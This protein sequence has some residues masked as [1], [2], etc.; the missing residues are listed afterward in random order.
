L[1]FLAAPPRRIAQFTW[2]HDS[3]HIGHYLWNELSGLESISD[4]LRPEKY[5]LIYD[6]GGA[7]GA[8]FYGPISLLF[9]EFKGLTID[10]FTTIPDMLS[11]AYSEGVQV[12]RFSGAFVLAETR[13]RIAN[14]VVGT[15]TV[16]V[17]R[18]ALWNTT[19]PVVVLGL[20]VENRTLTNL[21]EFYVQLCKSLARRFGAVTIIIDGHNRRN[22]SDQSGV[23]SSFLEHR[24]TRPVFEVE[25]EIA[26]AI[27]VGLT[28]Q[29][30][31]VIDCVGMP[32]LENIAWLSLAHY[33]VAPWGAGLAKYRWV[34]NL[35]TYV[36]ISQFCLKNKNDLYIYN[37]PIFMEDP[38]PV[39]FSKPDF[40]VDRPD[41]P[42][43][44]QMDPIH[45]PYYINYEAKIEPISDEIG[46]SIS[47]LNKDAQDWPRHRPH[48]DFRIEN[49]VVMGKNGE[50][51]LA[52]GGHHVLDQV[53]G[54]RK[55]LRISVANFASN[56]ENRAATAAA[57]DAQY[58]HVIFPDKQSVLPADFGLENL[59]CL[60]QYYAEKCKDVWPHVVYPLDALREEP[61]GLFLRT[62]TH[63]THLG[64]LTVVRMVLE[65]LFGKACEQLIGTLHARIGEE[66]PYLGDLGRKLE[67]KPE[68]RQSFI[69]VDPKSKRYSNNYNNGNNGAV[70]VY[71]LPNA[72]MRERLVVFGDSF[73]ND[74]SW[75]LAQMFSEVVFFRTPYLHPELLEMVKPDIV[76]SENVERYLAHVAPDSERPSFAMMHAMTYGETAEQR[77][78]AEA[79]SAVCAFGRPPYQRLIDRLE[80]NSV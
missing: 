68:D 13:K 70:S 17:A 30:V 11:N 69:A 2:P 9:P 72:P 8:A 18:Q 5:P 31:T 3:A 39:M 67:N 34:C 45:V 32:M 78:F 57:V 36:L 4:R 61:K 23:F 15:S 77:E 62:D 73:A 63:M 10:R 79:L 59:L 55:P 41:V 64:T 40:V 66:R 6:L 50:L 14:L 47:R 43:L 38:S 24:A 53:L 71:R 16:E 25:K 65:R 49:D 21:A 12:L 37:D 75:V 29:P 48:S 74:M 58:V 35:P 7:A 20:R 44:L 33:C 42:V 76:I 1:G 60:G 51:F 54:Y 46:D 26:A 27:K 22:V 28:G 52:N 56:I 19:G 80:F